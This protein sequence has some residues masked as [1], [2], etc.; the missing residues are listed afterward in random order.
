MVDLK[1]SDPC[2][3]VIGLWHLHVRHTALHSHCKFIFVLRKAFCWLVDSWIMCWNCLC[4]DSSSPLTT[5]FALNVASC[6][7]DLVGVR[8]CWR[9]C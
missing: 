7:L 3:L 5:M 8:V 1:G 2:V 9:Y 4:C 6:T